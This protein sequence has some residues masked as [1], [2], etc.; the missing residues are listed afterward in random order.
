V[1]WT[2]AGFVT[3]DGLLVMAYRTSRAEFCRRCGDVFRRRWSWIV[4]LD[5][6]QAHHAATSE[7]RPDSPALAINQSVACWA[8]DAAVKM[9][10]ESALRTFSQELMYWA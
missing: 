9:A 6:V 4:E 2:I 10:F 3:N 8:L 7:V 1:A 5:S